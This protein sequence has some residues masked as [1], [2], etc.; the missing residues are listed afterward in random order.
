ME[1]DI[2]TTF[3]SWC[4][5]RPVSE[6]NVREALRTTYDLEATDSELSKAKEIIEVYEKALDVP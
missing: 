3:E 1:N 6:R 5:A 2:E 4:A